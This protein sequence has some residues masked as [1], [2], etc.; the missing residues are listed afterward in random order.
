MEKINDINKSLA[1]FRS[2]ARVDYLDRL[3]MALWYVGVVAE[4]FQAH[5]TSWERGTA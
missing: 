2:V 5:L 4:W 1:G 3:G